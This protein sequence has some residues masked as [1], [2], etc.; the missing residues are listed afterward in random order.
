[1]CVCVCVCACVSDMKSCQETMH[2]MNTMTC[3]VLTI[4]CYR[5]N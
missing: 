2:T 1:M 3:D 4:T 5:V